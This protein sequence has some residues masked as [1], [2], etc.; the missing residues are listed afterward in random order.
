MSVEGRE[1]MPPRFE[2]GWIGAVRESR[3]ERR[4]KY[5]NR[6]EGTAITDVMRKSK[7][8]IKERKGRKGV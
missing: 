2:L 8:G 6:R 5:G 4:K 1:P 7:R 3:I